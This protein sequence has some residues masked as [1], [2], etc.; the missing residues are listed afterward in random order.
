MTR[1]APK[2][3]KRKRRISVGKTKNKNPQ[4]KKKKKKNFFRDS[5]TS[6]P[7]NW[8]IVLHLFKL[9]L[10]MSMDPTI[11]KPQKKKQKTKKSKQKIPKKKQIKFGRFRSK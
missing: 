3:D 6:R 8:L 1:G 10:V 11:P 5:S 4:G 9:L 2:K 7:I